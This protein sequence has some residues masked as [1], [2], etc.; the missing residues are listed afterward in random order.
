MGLSILLP[1]DASSYARSAREIALQI[2]A[3]RPSARIVAL[4]VL[5][6][7]AGSGNIL[8]DL[9]GHLGFE[10]AV[11]KPELAESR[12]TAGQALLDDFALAAS[13]VDVTVHKVLEV[14]GVAQTILAHTNDA[15]LVVMGLR[16]ETEERF[17]GQGGEMIAWLPPRVRTP[18]LLVPAGVRRIERL[19]IGYDGSD[20]A[21]HT[22]RALRVVADNLHVPIDAIYVSADG[23]GGEVL[24]EVDRA[25]PDHQ[26]HHHVVKGSDPH[27][28]LAETARS[29]GVSVLA[30]GFR[31]RNKLKDFL[32]GSL[33]EK[34]VIDGT[35]GVLLTH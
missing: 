14:G 9:P 18:V 24:A 19:A 25:L 1:L 17:H 28:T 20:S 15:D 32:F 6:V 16:G 35:L 7:R 8:E 29:L 5:N 13:Q 27:L 4:H 34:V 10:P 30:L 11:V 2:G 31:G 21:R 23:G 12:R 22:L 33:T 3:A 26:V